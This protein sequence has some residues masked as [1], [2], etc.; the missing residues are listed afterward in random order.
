M[1][2]STQTRSHGA[3]DGAI[4]RTGSGLER[5]RPRR[6]KLTTCTKHKNLMPRTASEQQI[7]TVLSTRKLAPVKVATSSFPFR[8]GCWKMESRVPHKLHRGTKRP[9]SVTA[10]GVFGLVTEP[11][12]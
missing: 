5:A 1:L 3:I 4:S 8:R 9:V 2:C 12:A 11:Q 6:T 10:W 7:A